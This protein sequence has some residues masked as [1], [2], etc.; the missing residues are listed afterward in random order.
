MTR[1]AVSGPVADLDDAARRRL[2]DRGRAADAEVARTVA[3]IVAFVKRDGDT[4]LRELARRHDGVEPT[5]LEVPP[6]E[7]VA[8]LAG[9]PAD[10]RAALDIAAGAIRRFHEAQRTPDVELE[11]FDGVRV[12]RRAE[13]LDRVGVYAPGGRAAYPSSVLM[14][15][16]PAKVAG[17]GEVVVCTPPGPE[18]RPPAAVL[19]ACALAGADRVFAIGGAGAVAAL[20]Y[21]TTSVPRVVKIVGPGNAFVTEAKRQLA[22]VVAI[23]SPAGPSEIVVIADGSADPRL[24][25]AELLAQ[26]EHDPDAAA[27]LVATDPALPEAVQAAIGELLPSLATADIARASFAARGALLSAADVPRAVAFSNAYGPEH[28]LLLVEEPRAALALVR[29]A[30][31]VFLGGSSS[32]AF[33]DYV[34]G[35]N[36]VLPTNGLARVY[37]GLG[38][39]DFVRTFTWQEV[40]A[41]AAAALAPVAAL[42][43]GTE[44]LPAHALAAELRGG[45]ALRRDVPGAGE[46]ATQPADGGRGGRAAQRRA[47][48]TRP[49]PAPKPAG[50]RRRAAYRALAPYDPGR[51]PI[52]VDLSDN[53][54]LWGVCPA[55]AAALAEPEPARVTRYPGVYA[56]ALKEAL[57]VLHG[58]A[59]ENIVTGCGSDDVIDS[60]VRAFAE[61]GDR[62]AFPDPTFGM[63]A[64]FAR[65]NAVEPVPVPLGPDF[66]LDVDALLAARAPITYVC[67]PN[68]P[69]G[70]VF[71]PASVA[72]LAAEAAGVVLLDEAYAD[73]AGADFA[74]A[75]AASDRLLVLRTFSKAYGLAGLRVGYAIGSATLVA[76]VEKSRGPYKVGGMAE[77]AALAVLSAGR[78]WVAQHVQRAVRGRAALRRALEERTLRCWPSGANFLLFAVPGSAADWAAALRRRGVALRAF[79]RL[80]GAGDCLRVTIGPPAQMER[81]LIALD[82]VRMELEE[83]V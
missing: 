39:A 26:A 22:G 31:T 61:P 16:I 64:G 3:D 34:T 18:G 33:G 41:S 35:A 10:V 28:L 19:A 48:N 43:A 63:V 15:V 74:A 13:P 1:F 59:P 57:A 53:T 77:A 76:E 45:A 8:A 54:N 12:G 78:G 51:A 11:T 32:V 75:A 29:G 17:V 60:A 79:P 67:N 65:M 46:A 6:A 82:A 30:G 5:A 83:S 50:P 52:A 9:L 2:F 47:P 80:A 42:L 14:G 72:R 58:V 20:A 81:F 44:G 73:Y 37:S 38:T 23:D 36:H 70:T 62:L 40:T 68:N 25:A 56:Q 71:P 21:G 24:V 4:A 69:S 55:A 27:V 66:S 49:L 7:C